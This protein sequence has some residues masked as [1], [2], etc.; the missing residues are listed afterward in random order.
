MNDETERRQINE[1]IDL[2]HQLEKS[3]KVLDFALSTLAPQEYAAAV[4]IVKG[5]LR[6]IVK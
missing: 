2:K 5:D 1:L 4:R 3:V 6:R